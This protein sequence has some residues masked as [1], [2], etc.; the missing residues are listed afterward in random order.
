MK[1]MVGKQWP[2]GY[3][4]RPFQIGTMSKEFQYSRRQPLGSGETLKPS[5]ISAAWNP[6]AQET[7]IGGILQGRKRGEIRG[8]SRFCRNK[9]TGVVV[10]L[11][12]LLTIPI[13]VQSG[14]GLR[15]SDMK[16]QDSDR[17]CV[18]NEVIADALSGW[19][20]NV[21][22]D[23]DIDLASLNAPSR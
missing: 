14:I 19:V 8:A 15:Y 18:K 12:R 4:F 17:R 21:Q 2:G 1:N 3:S 6:Y 23:F 5:N 13:L 16:T 9:T 10:N 11:M 22:D 7:L 20:P